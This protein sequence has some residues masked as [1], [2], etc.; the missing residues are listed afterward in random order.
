V[1]GLQEAE[2]AAGGLVRVPDVPVAV[3]HHG[4][5][6]LLLREDRFERTAASA[7]ASSFDSW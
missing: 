1:S 2:E 6:G 5:V 4:R 7:G 3:H